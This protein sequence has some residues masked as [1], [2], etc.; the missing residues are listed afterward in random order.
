MLNR[1]RNRVGVLTAFAGTVL[2]AAMFSGTAAAQNSDDTKKKDDP[3]QV[4]KGPEVDD[5]DVPGSSSTFGDSTMDP[6]KGRERPVPHMAFMAALKGLT[7]DDVPKNLHASEAQADEIKS[8]DQEFRDA[9]RA[10]MQEHRDEIQSLMKDIRPEGAQGQRGSRGGQGDR[11]QRGQR[12]QQGQERPRGEPGQKGEPGGQRGPRGQPGDGPGP[13]IDPS[14]LS[15]E[16]HAAFEKLKEI[17][18]GGPSIE[19]CHTKMWAVLNPGQQDY[20]EGRLSEIQERGA[21]AM[22]DGGRGAKRDG[23]R[24]APQDGQRQRPRGDGQGGG[25]PRERAEFRGPGP[26][27]PGG[28]GAMGFGPGARGGALAGVAPGPGGPGRARFGEFDGR[29]GPGNERGFGPGFER[30]PDAPR[31]DHLAARLESLP[32]DVRARVLDRLEAVLDRMERRFERPAPP[33][34]EDVPLPQ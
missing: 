3:S 1:S 16:Q 5:R 9:R 22:R 13:R 30:G 29:R 26:G 11:A 21:D 23:Q 17:R 32:P 14:T 12:G 4:L 19:E 6:V 27:G 18:A 25:P 8:L 20:V 10:Y 31:M 15:D 7:G 34:M 2:C 28:P 33:A 24:G